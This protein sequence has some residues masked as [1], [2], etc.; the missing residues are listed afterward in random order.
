MNGGAGRRSIALMTTQLDRT[1]DDATAQRER[2]DTLIIGGG[3]A[4]LA[5]AY[6][7]QE[8]GI[9][10]I[11]VDAHQRVGDTWRNRWDSLRLF[12]PATRDSLP[13][14]P[15][16]DRGHRF[17]TKDEMA[18]YLERYAADLGIAVRTGTR[19]EF[20]AAEGDRFVAHTSGGVIDAASVVVATGAFQRPRVPAFAPDLDPATVQ[21]HSSRYRNPSQLQDGP[22]LV[23]GPGNSGADIALELAKDRTTYLAGDHPGHIPFRIE[24][25]RGRL[26][27]PILWRVWTHV[28]NVHTPIG[29]KARVR[30]RAGHEPLIRVKP[31]DLER[32]GVERVPR[33][34]GIQG[35][36][37]VLA[38][39]RMLDVP[40]VVW[41]TG[42]R[43]DFGWI[44]GVETDER[45]EPVHREGVSEDH[46]GLYFLGRAFQFAFN[47]HTVGGVG[48]DAA[49]LADRIAARVK[50]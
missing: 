47:S 45:G 6:R 50:A 8:R 30:I 42:Y 16:D 15:M 3:Q 1:T 46:P 21:L 28:L 36:R 39:G 4:G 40:N 29:R 26:M 11:V 12:T 41:A 19:V 38:D 18:D 27:F 37:P 34:A 17:P 20:L 49:T 5:M 44:E 35:G 22:V 10:F 31:T 48:R 14:R 9:P 43:P 32:A 24:S 33:V 13:G 2:V 7:L 25:W 23:V